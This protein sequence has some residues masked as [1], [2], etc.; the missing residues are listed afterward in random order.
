MA[1]VVRATVLYGLP[2]VGP[3]VM[4]MAFAGDA[5][6]SKKADSSERKP[7]GDTNPRRRPGDAFED[8]HTKFSMSSFLDIF[9]PIA[10]MQFGI[11][12]KTS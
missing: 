9:L 4:R 7:G 12:A 1:R 10:S 5:S 8:P 2:F 11:A 3:V 6:S